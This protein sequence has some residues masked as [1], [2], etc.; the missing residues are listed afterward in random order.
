MP[1][2]VQQERDEEEKRGH[3]GQRHVLAVRE[4]GFCDGI[5]ATASDQTM[6]ANTISQLQVDT[7][8]DAGDPAQLEGRA[9]EEELYAER[10]RCR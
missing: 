5:T 9:N 8:P 7:D 10:E 1:E 3:N 6:S 4:P 2:L